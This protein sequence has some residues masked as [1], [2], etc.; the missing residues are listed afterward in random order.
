MTNYRALQVAGTNN[1]RKM[2]KPQPAP[3][4]I[5]TRYLTM[6]SWHADLSKDGKR[7]GA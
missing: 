1:A 3:R 5:K 4:E 2:N 7:H 6:A